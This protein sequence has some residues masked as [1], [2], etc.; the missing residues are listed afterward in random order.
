MLFS[1][2][3]RTFLTLAVVFAAFAEAMKISARRPGNRRNV[4]STVSC[5]TNAE[6]IR[7]NLPLMRPRER[8]LRRDPTPVSTDQTCGVEKT[9]ELLE[10]AYTI[11]LSGGQGGTGGGGSGGVGAVIQAR[12]NTTSLTSLTYYIGCAGLSDEGKDAQGDESY[13]PVGGGG[14]GTFLYIKGPR[15]FH[16]HTCPLNRNLS[17]SEISFL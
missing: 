6:C 10:G 14:G 7:N 4:D 9:L 15:E 16:F 13:I 2:T 3:L 8:H 17:V 12:L 1:S 11:T 5:R